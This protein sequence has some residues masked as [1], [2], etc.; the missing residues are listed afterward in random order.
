MIVRSVEDAQE[1]APGHRRGR[2]G[3][4]VVDSAVGSVGTAWAASII[5]AVRP[6]LVVGVVDAMY[7]NE[8]ISDWTD[9]LGGVDTFVLENVDCTVSPAS[10]LS[11][12]IPVNRIDESPATPTRWT[13]AVLD[14]LDP[15]HGSSEDDIDAVGRH[16]AGRTS[17]C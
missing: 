11:L 3:I 7:K 6:T 17:A 10:L 2:V 1:L 15:E 8:D 16:F 13:A 4:I 5:H 9:R 12:E 14:H